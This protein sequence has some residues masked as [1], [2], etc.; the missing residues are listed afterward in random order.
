VAGK[1]PVFLKP[2]PAA[3]ILKINICRTAK[4][5]NADVHLRNLYTTCDIGFL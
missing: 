2:V 4:T 1:R 5:T 3:G